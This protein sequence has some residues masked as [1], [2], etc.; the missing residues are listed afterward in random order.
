MIEVQNVTKYYGQVRA[1]NNVSF[2]VK[3][4]EIVGLLGP[5]GSGKTTLMRILTGFFPPTEG[6]VLVA[7]HDVEKASLEMRRK[8]GYLPENVVLY[9]DMSVRAFLG[10]SARVKAAKGA[11]R[12]KQVARVLEECGLA[13]M[14][15]RQ[16]GTLSKGYRQRV[17][18]AQALLCEPEVLILDEPTVGLDPN[19][20]IDMRELIR[21]LG[22]KT[23]I[24]LSSHILAEVAQVCHRVVIVNTG[25]ILAEDTPEGLSKRLQG[26]TQTRIRVE[27]PTQD[28][29][30]AL[31]AL[32]GVNDVISEDGEAEDLSGQMYVV[33]S[34]D[35]SV[36]HEIANT[37]VNRGW[38]L[39]ELN[40]VTAGLE[41][42][43]VRITKEEQRPAA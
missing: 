2:D 12:R 22:G 8:L 41:E 24:L 32:P 4:G 30:N 13:H 23:T 39:Q 29:Q 5:N 3:P 31:R 1:L 37:V 15:R 38:Q 36:T 21:G 34:E 40:P 27:G 35:R 25:Q 7:G 42:L 10:F 11:E 9:P 20:L 28:V 17:G 18:L 19:Q 26:A 14:A 33:L 6:K 43:F 16:M